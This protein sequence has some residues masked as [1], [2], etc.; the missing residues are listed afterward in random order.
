M[1]FSPAIEYSGSGTC[2][3]SVHPLNAEKEERRAPAGAARVPAPVN[4][5]RRSCCSEVQFGPPGLSLATPKGASFWGVEVSAGGRLRDG[6]RRDF[7]GT[8]VSG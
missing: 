7:D 6:E 8:P 3:R 4:F 1:C 2:L 5:T